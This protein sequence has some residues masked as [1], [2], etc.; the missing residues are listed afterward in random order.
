M[1]AISSIQPAVIN[2]LGAFVMAALP[3][4][5]LAKGQ[6]T[7]E[8]W[9]AELPEGYWN[10]YWEQEGRSSSSR[11][12]LSDDWQPI[13]E[14]I[15]EQG[16]TE[17]WKD[18]VPPELIHSSSSEKNFSDQEVWDQV[19]QL[20][21]EIFRLRSQIHVHRT[22]ARFYE[23]EAMQQH[24]QDEELSQWSKREARHRLHRARLLEH[25]LKEKELR[26]SV[27]TAEIE[28]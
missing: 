22:R 28:P 9:G 11:E 15:H 1:R 16:E 26:R 24:S 20:D 7:E 17:T 12:E 2:L 23:K 25:D 27:L 4:G 5:L 13:A 18:D 3:L 10:Q 14:G 19:T 6:E 8:R 21:E